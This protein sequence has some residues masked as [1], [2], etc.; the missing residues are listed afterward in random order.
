VRFLIATRPP[1]LTRIC[2]EM[3]DCSIWSRVMATRL[4]GSKNHGISSQSAAWCR[5]TDFQR[6]LTVPQA[7]ASVTT[8]FN[9]QDQLDASKRLVS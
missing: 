3:K 6:E 7:R 5:S 4:C 8:L 1:T 2:R 9:P